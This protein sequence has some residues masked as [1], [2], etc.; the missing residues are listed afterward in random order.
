[1]IEAVQTSETLV[2]WYQSTRRYNPEDSHLY[3]TCCLH[4]SEISFSPE[5]P[6]GPWEQS[7]G[8]KTFVYVSGRKSGAESCIMS[9]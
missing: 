2:N 9:L 4:E 8:E 3:V 6:R 7:D 5:T 1:M